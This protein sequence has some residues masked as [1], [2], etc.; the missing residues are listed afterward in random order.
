MLSINF[1]RRS[2]KVEV[3]FVGFGGLGF[4]GVHPGVSGL[5]P[6][7]QPGEFGNVDDLVGRELRVHTEHSPGDGIGIGA[8]SVS[9]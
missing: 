7:E 9:V 4:I 6:H 5:V 1:G 2:D 8:C 3:G